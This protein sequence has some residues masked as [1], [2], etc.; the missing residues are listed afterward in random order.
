[1]TSLNLHVDYTANTTAHGQYYTVSGQNEVHAIGGRPVEP[2]TSINLA[3]T[4]GNV[5]GV[6]FTGGRFEDTFNFNPLIARV[7][8]DTQ[9]ATLESTYPITREWY[10]T[11]LAT[12]NQFLGIDAVSRERL[13]V[14]PGQ[15]IAKN[16][17]AP[18]LGTQRL[19]RDLSF[20]VYYAPFE[21]TDFT[22]PTVAG[23]TARPGG[24]QTNFEVQVSDESGGVQ[25]VVVVYRRLP[26]RAWSKVE[27]AYNQSLGLATGSV[28]GLGTRFEYFV[29]AVDGTG[30][31][32]LVLNN[33]VPFLQT[34][35]RSE[36]YL[37]LV[38]R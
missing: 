1:M 31:V 38:R 37:P 21:T 13:V 16:S 27:L 25:R 23:V 29:Q 28:N 4:D 2:K 32:V 34:D 36:V 15:F 33:G 14:V 9:S 18:T 3:R 7:V 24:S 20:D 11:R 26:D 17:A 5:Q 22:P 10:P 6:L 35:G 12:I 19:Y 30:N 8:T